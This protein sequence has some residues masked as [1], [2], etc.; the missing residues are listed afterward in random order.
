MKLEITTVIARLSKLLIQINR[1]L[2]E[3]YNEKI[4]APDFQICT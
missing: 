4:S 2:L 3:A 1:N